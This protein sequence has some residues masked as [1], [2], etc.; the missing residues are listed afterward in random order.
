MT[1]VG[2]VAGLVGVG[3]VTVV[4]GVGGV[5]DVVGVGSVTVVTVVTVVTGVT[6]VTGVTAG[7]GLAG[8]LCGPVGCKVS[9]HI[10][11][12]WISR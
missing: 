11:I 3:F 7:A 6:I 8:M 12:R 1:G 2:G 5:A 9:E 4:T 10:C